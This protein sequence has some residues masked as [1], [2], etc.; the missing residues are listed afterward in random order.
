[1]DIDKTEEDI[2]RELLLDGEHP[3]SSI[4]HNMKNDS[5]RQNI[6][7]VNSFKQQE[8]HNI[9]IAVDIMDCNFCKMTFKNAGDKELHERSHYVFTC[10]VCYTVFR[11]K[12]DLEKHL[13]CIHNVKTDQ[14]A[15]KPT[16]SKTLYFE[17]QICFKAF[18][19]DDNL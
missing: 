4:I 9:D 6:S 15:V 2:F 14:G 10:E 18:A 3:L 5:L 8:K 16:K 12:S 11:R 7:K 13:S 1:M 17:C 19:K